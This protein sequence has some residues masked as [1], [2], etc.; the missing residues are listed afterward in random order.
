[1]NEMHNSYRLDEHCI[2]EIIRDHK[3]LYNYSGILGLNPLQPSF[4]KTTTKCILKEFLQNYWANFTGI[5]SLSSLDDLLEHIEKKYKETR[6]QNDLVKH[7]VLVSLEKSCELF[8]QFVSTKALKE[9]LVDEWYKVLLLKEKNMKYPRI[10]GCFS[11][12]EFIRCRTNQRDIL[13]FFVALNWI[14]ERYSGAW[15]TYGD[16]FISVV[17]KF[18]E[19]KYF[20]PDDLEQETGYPYLLA[21]VKNHF[22]LC[23]NE[24]CIVRYLTSLATNVMNFSRYAWIRENLPVWR[25][26]RFLQTLKNTHELSS[27]RNRDDTFSWKGTGIFLWKEMIKNNSLLNYSYNSKSRYSVWI[28][29][30]DI[31]YD[32]VY[33]NENSNSDMLNF[34]N[35]DP[36]VNVQFTGFIRNTP[37]WHPLFGLW[38]YSVYSPNIVDL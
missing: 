33:V 29:S 31:M 12:D 2:N 18:Y 22:L 25:G 35:I 4:G 19:G 26:I 30:D 7:D 20:H 11:P 34:K 38:V 1:M 13:L 21:S 27:H 36:L 17:D 3:I 16:E 10:S 14:L 9:K 23:K 8:K 24:E 6:Y 5:S 37:Y 28:I 15:D 32:L